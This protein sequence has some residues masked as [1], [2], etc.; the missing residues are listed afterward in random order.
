MV[1]EKFILSELWNQL[2]DKLLSYIVKIKI[3]VYS[4][5]TTDNASR[6]VYLAL[7]DCFICMVDSMYERSHLVDSDFII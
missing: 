1:Y 7:L 4:M 5:M 2:L 3:H 6:Q